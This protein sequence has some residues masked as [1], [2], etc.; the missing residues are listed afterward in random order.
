M[1]CVNPAHWW[2]QHLFNEGYSQCWCPGLSSECPWQLQPGSR[3]QA[4]VT[5]A[6][7][8]VGGWG[9]CQGA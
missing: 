1:V 7:V 4:L 2:D 9:C 5:A 8:G 3:A 6:G